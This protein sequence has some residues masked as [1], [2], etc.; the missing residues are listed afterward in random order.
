MDISGQCSGGGPDYQDAV[1]KISRLIRPQTFPL[2]VKILKKGEILPE[3]CVRPSKYGITISLCQW[4]TMA[5]RWGRNGGILAEDINCTPCLAALGL[6]K[7]QQ[8]SDFATYLLEMGYCTNLALAEKATEALELITPG[9][10]NGIAMFPLEKSPVEPDLVVMYGTP[11]QM[12]RLV[13]GYMYHSG[14]LVESKAT[15]FGFSCLSTLKPYWS[16][17]PAF[18]NPGRGERI[19]GG[20]DES[21]MC[22]SL[23]ARKLPQFLDG[24]EETHGKGTRYPIQ[25]YVFYQ[26]R[27]IPPMEKLDSK[28]ETFC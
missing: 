16:G 10:I 5:R 11:A 13:S 22:F 18:I 6:K 21:E 9:E 28:L 20:T 25:R 7:L 8:A 14:E 2:G 19:L 15:G 12:S 26:P 24:L 1:E 17:K 27:V 3:S 23:P 4:I